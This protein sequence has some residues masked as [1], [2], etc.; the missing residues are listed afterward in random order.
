MRITVNTDETR[1]E[2]RFIEDYYATSK[3]NLIRELRRR[4]I[5]IKY[6]F[7]RT[8]VELIAILKANDKGE[9]MNEVLKRL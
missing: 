7:M 4:E 8:K 1:P 2:V 6:P 5:P 9:D 3:F